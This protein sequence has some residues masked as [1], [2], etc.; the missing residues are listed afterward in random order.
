MIILRNQDQAEIRAGYPG[1]DYALDYD[2]PETYRLSDKS[3]GPCHSHKPNEMR[4]AILLSQPLRQ[5]LPGP[6]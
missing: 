1:S 6:L 4:L 5:N 2:K 3:P